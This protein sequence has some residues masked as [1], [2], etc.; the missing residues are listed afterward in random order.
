MNQK[1]VKHLDE[2][3]KTIK[4]SGQA[5]NEKCLHDC[6]IEEKVLVTYPAPYSGCYKSEY[7]VVNDYYNAQYSSLL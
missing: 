6:H 2:N 5:L 3:V 1:V 7:I 4:I